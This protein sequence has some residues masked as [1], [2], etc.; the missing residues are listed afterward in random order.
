MSTHF[1]SSNF[2]YLVQ[3]WVPG[4]GLLMT[5]RIDQFISKPN[6]RTTQQRLTNTVESHLSELSGRTGL[7][8]SLLY[9]ATT[10]RVDD[11]IESE[12]L[13]VS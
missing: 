8:Y 6:C 9:W 1:N 3:A 7:D 2:S 12:G 13:E 5:F 11:Y 10:Q 4:G